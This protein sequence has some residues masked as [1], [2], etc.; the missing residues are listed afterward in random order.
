[1]KDA[2]RASAAWLCLPVVPIIWPIG[3]FPRFAVEY[4]TRL[5]SFFARWLEYVLLRRM[6]CV[7]YFSIATQP[8]H[9]H[10]Q[11][12]ESAHDSL[13]MLSMGKFSRSRGPRYKLVLFTCIQLR[14]WMLSRKQML[15]RFELIQDRLSDPALNE[16]I[17][18]GLANLFLH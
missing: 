9:I 14:R 12:R 7:T 11:Q 10:M 18:F 3:T 1:M 5:T 2:T 15:A 4:D 17:N 6:K 8:Y 13:F 16:L